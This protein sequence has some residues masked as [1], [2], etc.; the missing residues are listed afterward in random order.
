MGSATCLSAELQL[1]AVVA[2]GLHLRAFTTL[3][4]PRKLKV[5]FTA[6]ATFPLGRSCRLRGKR[7]LTGDCEHEKCR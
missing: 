2:E 7:A 4:I 6:R 1:W 3:E 5:I